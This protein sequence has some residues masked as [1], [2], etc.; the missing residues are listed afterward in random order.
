MT[1]KDAVGLW[2]SS[3]AMEASASLKLAE[4]LNPFQ[5]PVEI[6][7]ECGVEVPT[8][9][10]K[11]NNKEKDLRVSSLFLKRTLNDLRA[12]WHSLLL[13]YTSQAG[14]IAAAAFENALIA[15]CVAG[16]I[17]RADKLLTCESVDSPWSVVEL[18]KMKAKQMQKEAEIVEETF[19][20]K[21][22]DLA[23][24]GIY[25]AYKW[26]CRI[27][28][29]TLP[30]ALHDAFSAS[31]ESKEFVVMAA[32][33]IREEDLPNK[34]TILAITVSRIHD[35]I[36]NFA[37]AIEADHDDP[38]VIFWRERLNTIIPSSVEAY[39]SA[40]FLLPF[41]IKHSRLA[42]EYANLKQ[43]IGDSLC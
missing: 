38:R 32:P 20:E 24:M 29:P 23:W 5:K 42:K 18:C 28:H 37:F 17:D 9:K 35:A 31:V 27:K 11:R 6:C 30:S 36:R 12:I 43:D 21:D 39:E 33:D 40:K 2:K 19:A 26:L 3:F 7:Y 34:F 15:S 22:F 8:L 16:N 1:R 4:M 13:G 14:T 25:G 10:C 41:D